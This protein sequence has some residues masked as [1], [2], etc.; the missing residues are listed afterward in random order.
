MEKSLNNCLKELAL[1]QL[2]QTS[3]GAKIQQAIEIIQSI[4]NHYYAVTEKKDE[5]DMLGIKA[6]TVM[7]FA[8]LRKIADGKNPSGFDADDWK[9]IAVSASEYAILP[10]D[11]KYTVFIF[12]L[13]ERY[14]RFSAEMIKDTVSTEIVNSVDALANE[15][16]YKA[17]QLHNGEISEV[18]YTEDCLWISLEAMIKLLASTASLT[19]DKRVAEFS[20]A[21]ASFAFEYGRLML[22]SREQEIIN[23]FIESQHQM[24]DE[25]ERKYA[26]FLEELNK[27]SEQFYSLIENA[28]DPNFREAFLQSVL[29][30]KAAGVNQE[31]ILSNSEDVDCFFLV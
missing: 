24:D 27:Q 1:E 9:D 15:L 3:V 6:A 28:F 31:E 10:D 11:K 22:Y 13:Y 20:Q 7:T 30:A 4:Q 26:D 5:L 29:L 8:V 12:D 19:Q 14:I 18:K 16:H 25:L 23:Q 2:M 17:E 21:L